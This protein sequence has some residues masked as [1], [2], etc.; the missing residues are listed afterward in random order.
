MQPILMSPNAGEEFQWIEQ[1][2][3]SGQSEHLP[4]AAQVRV[5]TDNKGAW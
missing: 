5:N 4:L 1:P 3:R 2:W